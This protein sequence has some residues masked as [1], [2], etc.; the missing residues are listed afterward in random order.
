MACLLCSVYLLGLY[1]PT[2]VMPRSTMSSPS[3]DPELG[4]RRTRVADMQTSLSRIAL[5]ATAGLG[6]SVALAACGSGSSSTGTASSGTS[7]V[8]A[9]TPATAQAAVF[10]MRSGAAGTYLVGTGG[11]TVYLFSADHGSTT[12]C[13][14]DCLKEW[15]PVTDTTTPTVAGASKSFTLGPNGQVEYG[16][17]LLYYFSG[18]HSAGDQNGQ[19]L[20]SFG[21]VWSEV[22]VNGAP[23]MA[24]STAPSSSSGYGGGYGYGNG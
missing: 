14:G 2:H 4:N 18:D 24:A 11:R 16:G 12:A 21:G 1:V 10:A 20:N 13:S 9:S 6:L 3:G 23:L 19:G 8:G 7:N 17:H 5:L 15:M 22:G